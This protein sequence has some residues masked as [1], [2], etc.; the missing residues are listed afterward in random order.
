MSARRAAAGVARPVGQC[1]R[2][3]AGASIAAAALSADAIVVYRPAPIFHPPSNLYYLTDNL[4]PAGID[5]SGDVAGNWY[6]EYGV[7]PGVTHLS[8]GFLTRGSTTVEL[9][10]QVAGIDPSG[11]YVVG[12]GTGAVVWANGVATTL[13]TLGGSSST[14]SAVNVHGAVV[15][16][17]KVA[18]DAAEHAFVYAAGAMHDLGTLGGTNSYAKGINASG[19]VVGY[20]QVA[21][22]AATHAFLYSGGVMKDLGSLGGDSAAE[23]I[24][25]AG[26]VTGSS[27]GASDGLLHPFLYSGGVMADLGIPAGARY[28]GVGKALDSVDTVV[29]TITF[30]RSEGGGCCKQGFLDAHGAML[31]LPAGEA[32]GVND[33]GQIAAHTPIACISGFCGS[34]FRLDPTVALPPRSDANGDGNTDLFWRN[35]ATGDVNVWLLDPTTQQV[36]PDSDSIANVAD[37]SWVILGTGDFDGDGKADLLWRNTVTGDVNVW[38]MDGTTIKAGSGTI[39]AIPANV[40]QYAGTGDFDHDGV[41][42]IVWRNTVTGDVYIWLMSGLTIKPGSGFVGNAP[43][44]TWK[45]IG[46]GDFDGDSRS[47]LLWQNVATGDID[48]WFL[49]GLALRPQ[50]GQVSALDPAL[51]RFVGVADVDGDF[52]DDIV[53]RNATTGDVYAWYMDGLQWKPESGLAGALSP[54][55]WSIGGISGDGVLYLSNASYQV[56]WVGLPGGGPSRTLAPTT[57]GEVGNA[58]WNLI[59]P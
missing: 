41:S 9:D 34:G 11:T 58:S 48:I 42:D 57:I 29:G 15:G 8:K 28:G 27:Y 5:A 51:W 17:S 52:K 32:Y 31:L 10:F 14:A 16:S 33:A 45:I 44:A 30:N 24:N 56:A 3:L 59:A 55:A 22:D 47:D 49:D 7:V 12:N 2:L 43:I 40:W 19:D 38:F 39:T 4:V 35:G 18:G 36:L 23:A 25:D 6:G 46:V 54:S 13:G 20:A 37:P 1:L 26:R 53:W 50:S 21:G